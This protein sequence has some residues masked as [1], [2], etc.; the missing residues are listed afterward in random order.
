MY[1]FTYIRIRKFLTHTCTEHYVCAVI[2]SVSAP[3]FHPDISRRRVRMSLTL[4]KQNSYIS[5][6]I[7]VRQVWDL[8]GTVLYF[9]EFEP[10]IPIIVSSINVD[11]SREKVRRGDAAFST[12]WKT[13]A[14]FVT[15]TISA[16]IHRLDHNS[17]A[18]SAG[19]LI[20]TGL[21]YRSRK[22]TTLRC[23]AVMR[24]Y[25]KC[26][27]ILY[28]RLTRARGRRTA[29]YRSYFQKRSGP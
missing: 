2:L 29:N 10:R 21:K 25:R 5:N 4:P 3:Q 20:R 23:N 11:R 14:S 18:R 15:V 8:G 7:A 6:G 13:H 28:T 1:T 9:S 22:A 24:L 27:H 26:S 19:R 17:P 16:R 12:S